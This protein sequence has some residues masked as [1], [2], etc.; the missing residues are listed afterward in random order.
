MYSPKTIALLALGMASTT[1]ASLP[2][3]FELLV[4]KDLPQ[5]GL[6][7][8]GCING[9]GHFV[10][11]PRACLPFHSNTSI[12]PTTI[13]GSWK[14]GTEKGVIDCSQQGS[15]G[16]A[17]FGLSGADLAYNGSTAFSQDSWPHSTDDL[18]GVPT[19]IGSGSNGTLLLQVHAISG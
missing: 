4:Y 18:Q 8:V 3:T 10:T 1:L 19:K 9:A 14:C 11:S 13:E 16:T 12:E 7:R 6:S 5:R 2:Y 15:S 17:M